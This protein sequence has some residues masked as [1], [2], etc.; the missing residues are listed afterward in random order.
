MGKAAREKPKRL[1]EKL[2]AIRQ[3]LGLS[4]NE[5]VVAESA[6]TDQLLTDVLNTIFFA[7]DS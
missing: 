4:Q 2:T 3:A 7:V 5:M 6:V 1:A